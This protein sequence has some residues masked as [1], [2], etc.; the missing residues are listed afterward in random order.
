MGKFALLRYESVRFDSNH[1][2]DRKVLS[3]S[4]IPMYFPFVGKHLPT[5]HPPATFSCFY[6]SQ[7]GI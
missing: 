6:F 5:P 2:Q 1:N 3:P 7:D 4:N